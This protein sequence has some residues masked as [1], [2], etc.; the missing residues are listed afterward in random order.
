MKFTLFTATLLVWMCV[1]ESVNLQSCCLTVTNTRV[2]AENIVNYEI[3]EPTG[4]CAIRAVR[5][6]TR[7]GLNICSDPDDSWAKRAMESV[8]RRMT[9]RRTIS[10]G[11]DRPPTCCLKVTNTRIPAENIVS[12]DIQESTGVC[13]P[14]AVRFHTRK[15]KIICS[16]P[17][18]DWPKKIMKIVDGR[19]T[20]KTSIKPKCFTSTT[21]M[22]PTTTTTNKTPKTETEISTSTT[23]PP[24]VTIIETS[25]P[26]TEISTSTTEPPKVTIIET[27]GPETEISTSTTEPPKV[28]TIET[29]L[30][31]TETSTT[32]T[33]QLSVSTEKPESSSSTAITCGTGGPAAP[34]IKTTHE[35]PGKGTVI[36]QT[37]SSRTTNTET[38]STAT[39]TSTPKRTKP[40]K[41]KIKILSKKSKKR[42]REYQMN[43]SKNKSG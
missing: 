28:T 23:E 20:A 36:H 7:K 24:K 13:A 12:Y 1:G 15:N 16:D 27:S 17:D 25:G 30:P 39:T 31:K 3:Q 38:T 33:Q 10:E 2:P 29:T 21:N 4:I 34:P 18:S 5:F 42:L 19:T 43:K 37:T 11:Q 35:T 40:S 41:L 9:G 32:T 26:K 22:I 14:R 6:H 8:D